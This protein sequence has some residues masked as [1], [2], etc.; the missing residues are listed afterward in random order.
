MVFPVIGEFPFNGHLPTVF[1]LTLLFGFAIA[2][3]SYALIE[4]PCREALRRWESRRAPVILDSSITDLP[5]PA[6]VR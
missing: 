2:A 1:V 4:S 6:P 3:V 5:E